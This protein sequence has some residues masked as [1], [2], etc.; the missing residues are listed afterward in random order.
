MIHKGGNGQRAKCY[1]DMRQDKDQ[2]SL[3][4]P[5]DAKVIDDLSENCLGK[6]GGGSWISVG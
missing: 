4:G 2:M 3:I 1:W 5:E 6:F